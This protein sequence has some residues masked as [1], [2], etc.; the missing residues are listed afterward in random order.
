MT[1]KD[2]EI[3]ATIIATIGHENR[4]LLLEQARVASNWLEGTNPRFDRDR[5]CGRVLAIRKQIEDT[6]AEAGD[7]R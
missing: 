4:G 5:F 6:L 7:L 3:V 2:F 1:R